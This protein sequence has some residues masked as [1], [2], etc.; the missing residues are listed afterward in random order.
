MNVKII[1]I[2]Y[3]KFILFFCSIVSL[4]ILFIS[5]SNFVFLKTCFTRLL[6]HKCF[7][8]IQFEIIIS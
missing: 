1:E 6:I 3:V 2:N 4:P 8:K 7:F 5:I